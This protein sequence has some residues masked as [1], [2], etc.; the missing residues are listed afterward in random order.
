MNMKSQSMEEHR[1]SAPEDISCCVITLSDSKYR[2]FKESGEIPESDTSGRLLVDALSRDYSVLEY[3]LIPDEKDK[4]LYTIHEMIDKGVSVIFTTGGT[5][6]GSRDITVETLRGIFEK[7]LDGFGE[8]FR[9]LSFKEL[10]A[11]AILSRATAGVY[12]GTLIFAL[13][14]SPNAVKLG[15]EIVV[16]EIGHLVKHLRE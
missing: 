9:Y 12:R 1:A 11:G 8:I 3:S 16:P 4:L 13:P 14:G 5:G 15:I 7:E 6:I 2:E 10:G